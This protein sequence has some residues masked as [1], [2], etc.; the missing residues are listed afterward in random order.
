CGTFPRLPGAAVDGH[1][2]LRS[3]DFPPAVSASGC[4]TSSGA[5]RAP[6]LLFAG[7]VSLRLPAQPALAVGTQD[8]LL[9]ALVLVGA[10]R[11]HVHV[12]ALAGA[13]PHRHD[14]D[15][16]APREDHLVASPQVAVDAADQLVAAAAIAL[17]RRTQP[18]D[19]VP[20]LRR[21]RVARRGKRG[22]LALRRL[23]TL[24]RRLGLLENGHELRLESACLGAGGA[25]A[26][27]G[28]GSA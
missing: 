21:F 24:R 26:L 19:G 27:G 7:L 15:A 17:D 14:G 18:S 5:R 9:A 1:P 13:S 4:S 11:R 3:P 20:E 28:G 8:Q 12:T 23:E 22:E 6:T 16:A 2:A 10:L 25:P